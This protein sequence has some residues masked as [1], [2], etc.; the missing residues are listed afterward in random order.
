MSR[1]SS[2]P[3]A[4][5][6]EPCNRKCHEMD[7]TL[8]FGILKRLFQ[9]LVVGSD[10]A[11]H[12]A[13]CNVIHGLHRTSNFG[14]GQDSGATFHLVQRH[15]V[16]RVESGTDIVFQRCVPFHSKQDRIGVAVGTFEAFAKV[17]QKLNDGQLS[18][19]PV[20]FFF[21]TSVVRSVALPS[22]LSLSHQKGANDRPDRAERLNP[23]CRVGTGLRRKTVRAGKEKVHK[24]D[25]DEESENG[26][27]GCDGQAP[28][29][30]PQLLHYVLNEK[31]LIDGGAEFNVKNALCFHPNFS[32]SVQ[33]ILYIEKVFDGDGV[34]SVTVA[35]PQSNLQ[36]LNCEFKQCAN[37]STEVVDLLQLDAL[38][39]VQGLLNPII[40]GGVLRLILTQGLFVET[41]LRATGL[42]FFSRCLAKQ[43][44]FFEFGG[45][46]WTILHVF[47]N[48]A[49]C[50]ICFLVSRM[51]LTV[52]LHVDFDGL[53]RMRRC[54]G[55]F[56]H[57]MK[58]FLSFRRSVFYQLLIRNHRDRSLAF[59]LEPTFANW[60]GRCP[61]GCEEGRNRSDCLKPSGDVTALFR[62][63]IQFSITRKDRQRAINSEKQDPGTNKKS[64]RSKR[65][66]EE[67]IFHRH[68]DIRPRRESYPD[69]LECR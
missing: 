56:E 39:R 24:T 67:C 53:T 57:F 14:G 48:V 64:Q 21:I 5:D 34:E 62:T 8:R 61:N 10:H 27:N 40:E 60:K 68:V 43:R 26:Q 28:H 51:M 66:E 45:F 47:F 13:R 63:Q 65:I 9:L 6:I 37:F 38:E 7:V 44:Q 30:V 16:E 49:T 15:G 52:L 1:I 18:L 59:Q 25:G 42:R 20:L 17:A 58:A 2:R 19:L 29:Y 50:C 31:T 41:K 12:S 36:F 23:G 4:R 54:R 35:H 11:I 46:L 69:W 33:T 3:Q 55:A 22:C 32:V